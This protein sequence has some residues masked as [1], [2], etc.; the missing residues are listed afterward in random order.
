MLDGAKT[1][2][3]VFRRLTEDD[4][5]PW[6]EFFESPEAL[7]YVFITPG[8]VEQ[9]KT[10]IH[11]QLE[12]YKRD[13]FGLYALI[14]ED[15]KMV[16][17]AGLLFQQVDDQKEIEISYHLIPRFWGQGYATE[18]ARYC[19]DFAFSKN[20]STSVISIIHIENVRSQQVAIRNGMII[21]RTTVFKG[22]PVDI[23]RT[24]L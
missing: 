15:K 20:V 8:D 5:F 12:R 9:C 3:L 14:N 17:Q 22:Y 6:L 2:R 10:W 4:Y 23:Y 1:S 24:N 18:A 11:R 7:K 13:G 21:E 16:G 19:K